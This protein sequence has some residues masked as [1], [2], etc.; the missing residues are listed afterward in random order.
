MKANT[1]PNI[2]PAE[3]V[4]IIPALLLAGSASG[5]LAGLFG[6]GGG[7]VITPVLYAIFGFM[8]VPEAV[9]VQLCIGTSLAIIIP[10]SIQSF[11][12]HSHKNVVDFS[13]LKIWAVPV[14][15]GVLIG[16]VIAKFADPKL[17]KLVFVS[18]ATF[19]A[20][21]LLF[22]A[23]WRL[24][25]E[26]PSTVI[27]RIYGVLVGLISALMG[28]GGGQLGTMFMTLYGRPIHQSVATSSGLGTLIAVPGAL[29]YMIVGWPQMALLPPL[30]I[31]Y[32]SFIGVLLIAPLSTF[33]APYGAK[34]AHKF[35]K[36]QLEISFGLFLLSVSANFLYGLMKP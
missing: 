31:G 5:I 13:I 17:F 4:F 11:R 15:T 27:I 20:I 12:A 25:N 3:L 26:L 14:I 2:S 23:S 6:V 1:L 24:G 22:G 10:T 16:G 34:L 28:I 36:R 35:S 7:L 33:I 18:V 19:S 32:V 8:N 30:S 21:R 9:R 29:S